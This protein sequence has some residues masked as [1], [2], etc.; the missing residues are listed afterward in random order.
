MVGWACPAVAFSGGYLRYQSAVVLQSNGG[1]QRGWGA[2]SDL[3]WSCC[4]SGRCPGGLRSVTRMRLPLDRERG[5]NDRGGSGRSRED[6]QSI[7]HR[8]SL[9][10]ALEVAEAGE[11]A[12]E[13]L[14]SDLKSGKPP[15]GVKVGQT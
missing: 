14:E 5:E 1:R 2:F 3:S 11:W 15:C 7:L 13:C 10:R 6:W 8:G 9:A 4:R 12:L